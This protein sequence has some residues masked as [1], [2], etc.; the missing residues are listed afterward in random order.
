MRSGYSFER[1]NNIIIENIYLSQ[2]PEIYKNILKFK[3]H[4]LSGESSGSV[5]KV[6]DWGSKGCWFK[7]QLWWSHCVVSLNKTLYPLLSTGTDRKSS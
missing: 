2:Q 6:L 5:G 7:T 1:E 4:Q 3:R